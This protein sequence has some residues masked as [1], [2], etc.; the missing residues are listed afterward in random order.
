MKAKKYITRDDS[1]FGKKCIDTLYYYPANDGENRR[2]RYESSIDKELSV[3]DIKK[4]RGFAKKNISEFLK[5]AKNVLKA[6]LSDNV[7]A[8]LFEFARIGQ[9]GNDVVVEDSEGTQIL[10]K[11]KTFDNTVIGSILNLPGKDYLH[12]QVLFGLAYYDFILKQICI[13]PRSIISD[14]EILRLAF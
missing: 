11:S 4:I 13:E 6:T 14:K 3:D 5:S 8:V 2:I 9:K 10:L 12:G 1:F 7:Y